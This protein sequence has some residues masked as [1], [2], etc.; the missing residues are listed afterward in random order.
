MIKLNTV[1]S[2]DNGANSV[3]F[4]EG[5]KGSITGTHNEG[6]MTGFLEGNVFTGTFHNMKVNA[7]GLI[8]ITFHES[9]FDAKWKNGMEPGPMRGKWVGEI[10]ANSI[11]SVANDVNEKV[12]LEIHL[13]YDYPQEEISSFEIELT[14][15][16]ES[17]ENIEK[18]N[19][20]YL[21]DYI[22]KL[23]GNEEFIVKLKDALSDF[24][25]YWDQYPQIWITKVNDVN[26]KPLYDYHFNNITD[27]DSIISI[28]KVNDDI[29]DWVSD[30]HSQTVLSIESLN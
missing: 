24:E 16:S 5:K 23:H 8:E 11:Q 29:E 9:G 1:Y 22:G 7:T 30:Y 6:T 20:E 19:F 28:L 26:L 27:D 4:T 2:I 10:N 12:T 3:V 13:R 25:L 21:E 18:I 14:D 17:I 15:F